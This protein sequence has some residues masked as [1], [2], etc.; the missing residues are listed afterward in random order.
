[1]TTTSGPATSRR[2]AM[3]AAA[4]ASIAA[5]ASTIAKQASACAPPTPQP[6]TITVVR[7]T[8]AA[9]SSF[10]DAADAINC[11]EGGILYFPEGVHDVS[12]PIS[13][14]SNVWV[15]G[16]GPGTVLKRT[17]TAGAII[18]ADGVSGVRIS[19]IAF[20]VNAS[21]V[22]NRSAITFASTATPNTDIT[23]ENCVFYSSSSAGT[24]AFAMIL[25]NVSR[26][27]IEENRAVGL[28][29]RCGGECGPGLHIRGNHVES[30]SR[31]AIAVVADA[32]SHSIVGTI[33]EGNL[34]E[35]PAEAGVFIGAT[36]EPLL[37]S[38]ISALIVRGNIMRGTFW[39]PGYG[40]FVRPAEATRDIA[41]D[42]NIIVN[43]DSVAASNTFGILYGIGTTG[44][45]L[46]GLSIRNN[47]VRN[48]DQ[49]GIQVVATG[50]GITIS[51]N[52][53]QRTRG[54]Q[55]YAYD[56]DVEALMIANNV[57]VDSGNHGL[58]VEGSYGNV[59]GLSVVGNDIENTAGYECAGIRL[60]SATG[61]AVAG[62][63]R[64]NRSVDTQSTPTQVYGAHEQLVGTPGGTFQVRYIGND[65]SG[66][67]GARPLYVGGAAIVEDNLGAPSENT[68]SVTFL[69]STTS[70]VSHGLHWDPNSEDVSLT[71]RTP[72]S[73]WVSG[74]IGQVWV[75]PGSTG[76]FVINCSPA[77]SGSSLTVAW[78]VK[79]RSA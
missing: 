60:K 63:V 15:L 9:Y 54:V 2:R 59:V 70:S 10:Q 45:A 66:N 57:V 47:S 62:D 18:V 53:V 19:N 44:T 75:T 76:Q 7:A 39:G 24:D 17:G 36:A 78:R 5:M 42:G 6:S 20:D 48:F 28:D 46:S 25:S 69:G 56:G 43:E 23:V 37:A 40:I 26:T 49:G 30:A 31:H 64:A 4:G 12:T 41:I 35:S 38:E 32:T 22:T 33:I 67:T 8:D 65:F 55:V 51:G 13:I 68:G 58:L 34:I 77:P 52:L 71:V 14:S 29:I 16:A 79:V 50:V 21:S 3:F 11:A 27:R 1:M 73:N 72:P 61:F 74:N